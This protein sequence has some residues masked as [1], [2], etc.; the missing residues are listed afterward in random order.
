MEGRTTWKSSSCGTYSVVIC[1]PFKGLLRERWRAEREQQFRGLGLLLPVLS[2]A[3]MERA[4][5]PC[6][7]VALLLFFLLVAAAAANGAQLADAKDTSGAAADDDGERVTVRTSGG[8]GHGY[9]S[10]SGGHP[11]GGTPGQGGA[12]GVDPRNLNARSHR[13]GSAS[14]RALGYTSSWAAC[15]LAGAAAM[16]VLV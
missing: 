7:V 14:S 2:A 15:A 12:G 1:I 13:N 11:N 4:K 3:A 5:K 8:H 9:S 6:L 10:H 16:M